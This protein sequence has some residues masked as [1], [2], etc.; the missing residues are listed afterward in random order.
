M[1]IEL[2]W[3][4]RTPLISYS[5]HLMVMTMRVIIMRVDS[6]CIF[7]K[8]DNRGFWNFS[9][10]FTFNI[11]EAF[12]VHNLASV[13]STGRA[14]LPAPINPYTKVLGELD[15]SNPREESPFIYLLRCPS[16]IILSVFF[17]ELVTIL[18][19]VSLNSMELTPSN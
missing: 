17:L 13:P 6:S 3:Y 18:N 14:N 15:F 9:L 12:Y 19:V 2:H 7:V 4:T 16:Y 10:A 11:G 1:S 8:E 5:S